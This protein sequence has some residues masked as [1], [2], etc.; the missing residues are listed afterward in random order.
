[1]WLPALFFPLIQPIRDANELPL[2][3]CC[4]CNA[5][6]SVPIGTRGTVGD[7]RLASLM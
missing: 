7:Q 1:M 3:T 5:P 6:T 2:I 4:N